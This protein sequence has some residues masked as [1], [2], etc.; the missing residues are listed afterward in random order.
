MLYLAS[1]MAV[2]Q[3][4]AGLISL[5]IACMMLLVLWYRYLY[6]IPRVMVPYHPSGCSPRGWCS[7]VNCTR[8]EL[9]IYQMICLQL[10]NEHGKFH[11]QHEWI[12]Q[13]RDMIIWSAGGWRSNATQMRSRRRTACVVYHTWA[14]SIVYH[15]VANQPCRSVLPSVGIA[16]RVITSVNRQQWTNYRCDLQRNPKQPKA[17]WNLCKSRAV[18]LLCAGFLAFGPQIV[19]SPTQY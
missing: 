8:G 13:S 12:G 14:I 16:D 9:C 5:Y 15:P 1:I 7:T 2:T 6:I 17:E 19:L 18:Y 11:S 4:W 3:N 10:W